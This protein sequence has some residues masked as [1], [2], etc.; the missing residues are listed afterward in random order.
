MP[1][2]PKTPSVDPTEN[3]G[4]ETRRIPKAVVKRLSLYSRILQHLERDKVDKVSSTDLADLL[5]L[6]SAQVRKDLA[7]FGQFGIPGYG[8]QVTDLR[9][10]IKQILGTDRNIPVALIGVGHLGTA[11]LSYAGFQRQ[12][13]R[14][15]CAFDVVLNPAEH[16]RLPVPVYAVDELE[17]RI[18][19]HSISMAILTVPQEAAQEISDRLVAAGISAIL[20]FVPMRLRTPDH[21]KVHYVDLA[22]EMESLSFY[23]K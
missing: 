13:F 5:G 12:G 19:A 9:K 14:V 1:Y 7:T 17:P 23:L 22:I 15:I 10:R 21:V 3:S 20:N 6:N 16:S 11:L 4:D 18:A 8:Y 2:S